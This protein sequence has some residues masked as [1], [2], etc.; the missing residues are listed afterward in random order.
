MA[1]NRFNNTGTSH[2]LYPEIMKRID[3]LKGYKDLTEEISKE[4]EEI[5]N[6][7]KIGKN[8]FLFLMFRLCLMMKMILRKKF[9]LDQVINKMNI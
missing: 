8:M 9:S 2:N 1:K 6:G 5:I 3:E 4:I 7:L